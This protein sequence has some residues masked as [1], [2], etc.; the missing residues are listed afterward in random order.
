MSEEAPTHRL[1][2]R[3]VVSRPT[4]EIRAAQERW[5]RLV[6]IAG[7]VMGTNRELLR[8]LSEGERRFS[9]QASA[10]NVGDRSGLI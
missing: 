1:N 9:Q 10:G 7:V 5:A 6:L 8:P 2:L 4:S 3:R